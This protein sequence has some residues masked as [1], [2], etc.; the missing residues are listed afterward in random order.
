MTWSGQIAY[1]TGLPCDL[2]AEFEPGTLTLR[3]MRKCPSGSEFPA[4]ANLL[5]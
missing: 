2:T 4:K 3:G 1:D 5:D